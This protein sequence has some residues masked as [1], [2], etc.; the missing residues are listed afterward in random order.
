MTSRDHVAPRVPERAAGSRLSLTLD[1][2]IE[3]GEHLGSASHPPLVITL[4]GDLGSGKTTLAQAICKGY[5]VTESVTSPTFAIVHRYDAPRSA[6]YHLDLYR[7]TGPADLTNIGWDDIVSSHS[8]VL[9]EWPERAR[10]VL[11]EHVPID[12]EHDPTDASRRI[13]LAG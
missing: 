9:I 2:L 11:P 8:L 4:A 13:L 12:L 7:L 6:V 3:W 10:G 1:A 5:G